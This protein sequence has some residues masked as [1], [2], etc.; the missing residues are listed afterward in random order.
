MILPLIVTELGAAR[1]GPVKNQ[2]KI[3][4]FALCWSKQWVLELT[5][6]EFE[7]K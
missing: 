4:L 6:H 1:S 7:T 3:V 2:W 5:A